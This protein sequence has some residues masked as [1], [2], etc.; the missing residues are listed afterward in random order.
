MV[1]VLVLPA[2]WK[3]SGSQGEH[4][5]PRPAPQDIASIGWEASYAA[6]RA[7]CDRLRPLGAGRLA[8]TP[9]RL[10]RL[11][12]A[13][14]RRCPPPSSA[15]CRL[16]S[17]RSLTDTG[18]VHKLRTAPRRRLTTTLSLAPATAT[19]IAAAIFGLAANRSAHV[20]QVSALWCLR[21][22]SMGGT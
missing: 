2:Q 9:L 8:W 14:M 13:S 10:T 11:C 21:L 22:R 17:M 1:L 16:F 12:C 3:A 5:R 7:R 20:H 4:P 6:S 19:R 18:W 15:A